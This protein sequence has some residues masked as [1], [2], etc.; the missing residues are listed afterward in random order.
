LHSILGAA[1]IKTGIWGQSHGGYGVSGEKIKITEV[2]VLT[3]ADLH[4]SRKLYAD[5]AQAV[6][7]H[8]PDLVAMV[9]DCL[10]MGE[11]M[12]ARL[13]VEECAAALSSLQCTNVVFVRGNH[14]DAN[15]LEFA[16]NWRRSTRPLITLHGEVIKVGPLAIV[17]FPCLLGSEEFFIAPRSPLPADP[18]EWLMDHIKKY[19]TRAQVVWLMHEPPC[20][21]IL[22]QE[23]GPTAGNQ[24]WTDAVERFS[25]WLVVCGHDHHTPIKNKRWYCEASNST[26]INAG[27]TDHEK[28]HYSVIKAKFTPESQ[29]LPSKMSIMA[30]PWQETI[31]IV[32]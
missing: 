18:K 9:G 23:N 14:E 5:L 6:D 26:C 8:R 16:K 10:H 27:Q 1:K 3:A 15:W 12:E 19:G 28:L 2:T 13:N 21:T 7:K 30:F 31:E 20:G 11:D 22:S 24:K 29:D 17:G 32:A 4:Q 25:P